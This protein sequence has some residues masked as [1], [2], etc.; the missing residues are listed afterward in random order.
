MPEI[1]IKKR[2]PDSK[3]EDIADAYDRGYMDGIVA[4]IKSVGGKRIIHA[5]WI[6]QNGF[7]NLFACSNCEEFS[8]CGEDKYCRHCGAIMDGKEEK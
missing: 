6:K 3:V 1:I 4:N 2:Y 7:D 5:H 8:E